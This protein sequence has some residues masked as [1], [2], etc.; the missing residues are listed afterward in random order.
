MKINDVKSPLDIL[1][2]LDDNIK[3][4]WVGTDGKKRIQSMDGFRTYYKTNSVKDAIKNGVGTCIEQVYIT[5][6]FL[7]KLNIKNEMFCTRVFEDETFNDNKQPERMHCFI[8]F[9]LNNKVFQIV[10]AN[11][12]E[13]GIYIYDNKEDALSKISEIYEKMTEEEYLK[14]GLKTDGKLRKLT[15]FYDV[16]EGLSFKDFNLYINSLDSKR[17]DKV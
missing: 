15:E 2:Y 9:Y 16:K 1:V 13:K 7:D 5:K 14:K 11:L 12:E 8:I 6:F 3:Y 17:R 10:H 4:G